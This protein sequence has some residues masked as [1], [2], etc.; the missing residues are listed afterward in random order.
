[1]LDLN[2]GR[3]VFEKGKTSE[4]ECIEKEDWGF[5]VYFALGFQEIPFTLYTYDLANT[6]QNGVKFIENLIPG[7]KNHIRNSD[8]FRQT[9]ESRKSWNSM[10]HFSIITFYFSPHSSPVS[11]SSNITY[12]PQEYPIKVQIFRLSTARVKIYQ[13]PQVTFKTKS[14]FFFKVS[15]TLQ[16]HERLFFCTVLAE[17][18]YAI[19]AEVLRLAIA[20]IKIQQIPQ[21]IFGTK[22]EISF[23]LCMVLQCYET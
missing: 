12:F 23:K 18:L 9:V 15:V 19:Q 11:F 8:N 20:R 2:W 16:F 1:M 3:D 13:I 21:V 7:L 5:F 14:Q 6:L 22:S 10:G 4:K 17:T